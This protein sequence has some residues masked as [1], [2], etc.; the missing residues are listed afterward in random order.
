VLPFTAMTINMPSI[1]I[2]HMGSKTDAED[3]AAAVLLHWGVPSSIRVITRLTT[4][5]TSRF[6]T[7]SRIVC[8]DE[9]GSPSDVVIRDIQGVH[10]YPYGDETYVEE[11]GAESGEEQLS[12]AAVSQEHDGIL[13]EPSGQLMAFVEMHKWYSPACDPIRQ[14]LLSGEQVALNVDSDVTRSWRFFKCVLGHKRPNG[15]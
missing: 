2:G 4:H 15:H 12:W 5:T 11:Q 1:F 7:R 3:V 10:Q 6:L 8:Y 14:A 13:Y 9:E